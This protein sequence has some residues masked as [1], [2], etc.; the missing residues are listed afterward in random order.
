MSKKNIIQK[1]KLKAKVKKDGE[2]IN[3][4]EYDSIKSMR[5][6]LTYCERCSE[7]AHKNIISREVET[8]KLNR[9][10][11]DG[12]FHQWDLFDSYMAK[13]IKLLEEKRKEEEFKMKGYVTEKKKSG[14]YR[15]KSQKTFI[16]KGIKIVRKTNYAN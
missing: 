16:I 4:L 13:F 1:K 7:T 10:N 6:H 8:K 12:I 9:V 2:G 11:H 3:E 14:I 15:R 5:N